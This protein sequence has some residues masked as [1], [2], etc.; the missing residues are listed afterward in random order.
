VIVNVSALGAGQFRVRGAP[1][2]SAALDDIV[3]WLSERS[4]VVEVDDHN[5]VVD[6]RCRAD[7]QQSGTLLRSL[8]DHIATRGRPPQSDRVR[9]EVLHSLPG[10]VRLRVFGSHDDD[11]PRIAA[12]LRNRPGVLRANGSPVSDSVLVVFDTEQTSVAA[13]ARVIESTPRTEWPE[14]EKL[15]PPPPRRLGPMVFS[16]AVLAASATGIAPVPVLSAAVAVTAVP[17]LKR[18]FKALRERRA[19]VDMLDVAAVAMSVGTGQPA[20]GAFIT[21]LL[22]IGDLLLERMGDRARAAIAKL[23]NLDAPE[24]LR[25]HGDL[26]ERVPADKLKPGDR[27]VVQAGGRVAADGLVVHGRAAVDEKALTGESEPR[28]RN[29]GDRVLA[30]TVVV[31]GE[32][33]LEIDRIG[34]DTTAAKI[35]QILENAGA[36]PTTLQRQVERAADKL[37][38]PT[39]G[40]A[41]GAFAL[42]GQMTRATSV[43]ITDFGTGVRVALPVSV[44]A[45]VT[46]AARQGVLVKGAQYLERLA[47]TD[48]VI[49][50]KTG[51]LTEGAPEV[52]AVDALNGRSAHELAS[53]CAGIES[54]GS[55][56]VAEALRRYASRLGIAPAP[57]QHG[58]IQRTVGR[59]VRA[60][61]GGNEVVV[62]NPRFL[63]EL[64][65]GAGEGRLVIERNRQ[66]NASS[67]MVAVDGHL[68]GV[69]AHADRPRPESAKVVERL[70]ARGRRRVVLLSGDAAPSVERVA[71]LVGVDEAH[72]EMLPEDKAEF[73]RAQQRLGKV[74]AMVGD[75]INDAPALALADVGISLDGSTEVALE[76]ADVVLLEGGLK[77]LELAF[78]TGDQAMRTVKRGLGLIL[79]PNAVAI[80]LAALGLLPPSLAAAINNGS[81]VVAGLA[82]LAPLATSG[83]KK[84]LP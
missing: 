51:T 58:T 84:D 30:A 62:G 32:I 5:G 40:L 17:P 6:V 77:R 42:S 2:G 61:V 74:V 70:K 76:T 14:A 43:L 8:E 12:L 15:P 63:R 23:V 26:L 48:V 7:E 46:A 65:I 33:T 3:T 38:L 35:V 10:R 18:A 47:K 72:G 34:S 53:L 21:W 83:R 66:A 60:R 29:P 1:R 50:D 69:I 39:F 64:G 81:T 68:E 52:V 49:F 9:V 22:S 36:K 13:L 45:S 24:A 44:L 4:Q 78:A 27:I 79:V 41:G 82:G 71:R 28:E 16:S 57:V 25:Q 11:P 75:G 67:L 56:P 80:V 31:D 20:T 54:H 19:S 73:V 59:G 37:V 55:H